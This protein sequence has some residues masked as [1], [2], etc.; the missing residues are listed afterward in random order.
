MAIQK[1]RRTKEQIQT[2][3]IIKE[4]LLKLGDIIADEASQNS[5][6]AR[7]IYYT[8]DR[9]E[10]KG[11]IRKAGG[12][13][14]DSINRRIEGDTTLVLVQV[15][16]GAYQQPNELLQSVERHTPEATKAIIQTITQKIIQP[17]TTNA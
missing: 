12:T 10:P 13:L 16:Y 2:D 17:F 5:R 4:E 11:T 1:K 3:K 6:V 15:N 14:R 9:V 7:D 8:T